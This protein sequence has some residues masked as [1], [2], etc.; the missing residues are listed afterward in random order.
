[1]W[2]T[3]WCGGC[4]RTSESCLCCCVHITESTFNDM[5]G[6]LE[7]VREAAESYDPACDMRDDADRRGCMCDPDDSDCPLGFR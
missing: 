4:F 1:M 6:E 3:N 5:L 2:K 7:T